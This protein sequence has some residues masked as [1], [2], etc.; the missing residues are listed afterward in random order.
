M[1]HACTTHERD[2]KWIQ[3]YD[4]KTGRGE[5]KDVGVDRAVILRQI[6]Y[7]VGVG[8]LDYSDSE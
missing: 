5:L 2:D 4:R 3:N 8:G 7:R 1:E 6:L